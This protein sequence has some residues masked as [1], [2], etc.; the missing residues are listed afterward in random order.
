MSQQVKQSQYN[1]ILGSKNEKMVI[2]NTYTDK[3]LDVPMRLF[4]HLRYNIKNEELIKNGLQV[5]VE[6]DEHQ[7]VI[8][9][10]YAYTK[11]LGQEFFTIAVTMRCNHR[12]E[13][14]FES[15]ILDSS[16]HM[17]PEVMNQT[18]K[19]ITEQCNKVGSDTAYIKWFGGEPLL[20]IEAIETI[21]NGLRANGL[22]IR[23][24][25]YTNGN[26][27]TKKVA[28]KLKELGL[29]GEITIPIDGLADTYSSIRH[30]SKQQFTTLIENI[31]ATQDILKL[32]IHINVS[33]QSKEEALP[34][35][36]LLHDSDIHVP[37]KVVKILDYDNNKNEVASSDFWGMD[38]KLEEYTIK[39]NYKEYRITVTTKRL[40]AVCEATSKQPVISYDGKLYRCEHTI[41]MPQ[42]SIGSIFDGYTQTENGK[43]WQEWTPPEKCKTC[44]WFPFCLGGC[45]TDYKIFNK[46][47]DCTYFKER[48]LKY[49]RD[50]YLDKH[51]SN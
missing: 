41:D 23:S 8:E 26:L 11:T 20:H 36:K 25:M 7:H 31:K 12:C 17:T 29:T 50:M 1:I 13:Y 19:F 24:I 37:I 5:P 4:S 45:I 22:K 3:V 33:E 2:L 40:N 34:L 18:I 6:L 21:V 46:E 48:Q 47:R 16:K 15:E 38:D 30:C 10:S 43:I 42:Y 27:L 35:L 44:K 51:S 32:Y 9:E 49:Y 14:C 39:N 28:L